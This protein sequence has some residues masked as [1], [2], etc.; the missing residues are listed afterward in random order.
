MPPDRSPRAAIDAKQAGPV[1]AELIDD[2]HQTEAAVRLV[3]LLPPDQGDVFIQLTDDQRRKLLQQLSPD[4]LGPILDCLEIEDAVDLSSM[5]PQIALPYVLDAASPDVAADVLK[6]L[7]EL[8]AAEAIE[9]METGN[10]VASL[11]RY[12]DDDAGGLMTPE[13]IALSELMTVNQAMSA[14]R[15]W[16]AEYESDD[17]ERAY[18]VDRDGT[19]IGSVGLSALILAHPYQL[20]SLIMSSAVISVETE[21]DQEEVARLME[22][23]DLQRIPVTDD[24][25]RLL[26]SISVDDIIDV[27]EEEATEDMYRMVGVPETEKTTG[28]FWRS[29]RG[30]LPWLCVNLGTALLAGLVVTMFESTMAKAIAL[31]AFLPVIAGQGGIAGT[32]TLTLL[33]RSLALDELVTGG[34]WRLLAKE[35]GLG[36]V[37][38]VVVG[39]LVAAVAYG[40]HRNE[41]I[42]L[43]VGCAM[44]VNMMVA[45]ISG[46]AVPLGL[47]A[48]RID[49][50]LASAVAVTTLT[51]VIGFLIYLGLAAAM[52]GLIVS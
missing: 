50:A 39:V 9:S 31:A 10:E 16:A 19:L 1:V 34:A 46:V 35:L 36:V 37:H 25:G 18:V 43:V 40:W 33:V 3:R 5:I 32:Q 51:D 11:L 45:G 6:D 15:Q 29:V 44:L 12:E 8:V 20:V 7:P 23:Y 38:G 17:I 2:G 24:G 52:I 26:G 49:P 48:L 42:A 47:R 30:R 28:P 22:K 21:T 4:T 27:V 13:F 14:I 41:Y